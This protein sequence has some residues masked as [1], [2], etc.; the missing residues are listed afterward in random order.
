MFGS[1][2]FPLGPAGGY[3]R[4]RWHS[5]GR[6]LAPG[7]SMQ[8]TYLSGRNTV[9]RLP[10]VERDFASSNNKVKGRLTNGAKVIRGGGFRGVMRFRPRFA[11]YFAPLRNTLSG[12]D[13]FEEMMDVDPVY[14]SSGALMDEGMVDDSVGYYRGKD[15]RGRMSPFSGLMKK[16]VK[17]ANLSVRNNQLLTSTRAGALSP[18]MKGRRMGYSVFT[19]KL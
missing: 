7:V 19:G 5:Y 14:D 18:Y 11:P 6:M 4:R 8:D 15:F 16:G 17:S 9:S 1:E 2:S 3:P 10:N 13:D 12:E